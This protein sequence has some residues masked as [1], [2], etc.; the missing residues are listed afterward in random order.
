VD[1]KFSSSKCASISQM[2]KREPPKP[3][4]HLFI[5]PRTNM[6]VTPSLGDFSD[7]PDTPVELT[8]RATTRPIALCCPRGLPDS[9]ATARSSNGHC[10][11]T[12]KRDDRTHRFSDQTRRCA[13]HPRVQRHNR[14]RSTQR[15]DATVPAFGRGPESSC[16]DRMRLIACDRM[17]RASDQFFVM[18]C[19]NGC[20]TGCAG[21]AR[22]RT[23]RS[24]TLSRAH[25][26]AV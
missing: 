13:H 25:L 24:A 5:A 7:R 2:C 9:T 14:T 8:G 16:R 10:A 20:P 3:G 23:R 21:S 6:A 18:H 22:D 26:P 19:T 11:P 17:R 12:V 1:G 15:P 4:H